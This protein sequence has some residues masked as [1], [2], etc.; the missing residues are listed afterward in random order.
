M[1]DLTIVVEYSS[2]AYR[3]WQN[4]ERALLEYL[5]QKEANRS[6][7]QEEDQKL[8]QRQLELEEKKLQLEEMK[9]NFE[10]S[11]RL[12]DRKMM[13]NMMSVIMQN[14]LQKSS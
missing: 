1:L 14:C 8:K 4:G 6:K 9:W 10:K 2:S 5:Q 7:L 13:M 12:A 3:S 11:E